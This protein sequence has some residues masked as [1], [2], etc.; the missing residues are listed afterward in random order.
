MYKSFSEIKNKPGISKIWVVD[1]T[2]L[3]PNMSEKALAKIPQTLFC[4]KTPVTLFQQPTYKVERPNLNPLRRGSVT[5][6]FITNSD[7]TD[8]NYFAFLILDANGDYY[9]LGSKELPYP[10]VDITQTGGSGG[11]SSSC[12]S[13]KVTHTSLTP[14]ISLNL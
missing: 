4:E 7:L 1:P 14:L 8:I 13:V 3:Q 2:E 10:K 12:F 9:L 11:S 6:E 5:L